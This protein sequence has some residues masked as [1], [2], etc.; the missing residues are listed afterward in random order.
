MIHS[1]FKDR[2]FY[3]NGDDLNRLAIA[4]ATV[5]ALEATRPRSNGRHGSH[6]SM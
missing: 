5:A 1:F 4:T 6:C 3:A 2:D